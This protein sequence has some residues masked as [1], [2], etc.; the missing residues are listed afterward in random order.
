MPDAILQREDLGRKLLILI[1]LWSTCAI[2][3]VGFMFLGVVLVGRAWQAAG[4]LVYPARRPPASSPSDY[5]LAAEAISFKT[6]DGLILHGWF[7][8]ASGQAKGT[9]VFSHG[10]A[11]DCS[12]DLVYVPL[13]NRAAYNVCLF[14]FRGHGTSEGDFTSVVYY[15]RG[16]LMDAIDFLRRKGIS[17]VGLV[18]FSMGGAIALATAPLCPEVVAVVS[19]S[20]FGELTTIIR[21][22]AVLRGFPYPGALLV[23]WLVELL[24]SFRVRANLFSADPIH[25]IAKISPR[26]VL[27]MHGEADTAIPVSE[28]YRLFRAA[29]EP[30]ELWV[31]PGAGHRQIEAVQPEEY[32]RRLVQF[33]DRAFNTIT[34]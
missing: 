15:E 2:V 26:P 1:G 30:K 12:P 4:E 31:V 8:P 16:D 20:T 9:L 29:R 6:R 21:N 34:P 28:A 33:F 32:R 18:G 17:R 3:L 14:D 22:A 7:V 27:I 10:Y 19:D 25:T 24:A 23:G 11:G 5:G 13:L